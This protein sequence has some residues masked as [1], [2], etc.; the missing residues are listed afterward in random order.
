MRHL[1]DGILQA[2]LDRE[3]S[4]QEEAEAR[5]VADHL[6][7]CAE[8][9]ARA[10]ELDA[11]TRRSVALLAGDVGDEAVPAYREVLG[12]A[13]A[14]GR[15]RRRR[16]WTA[17]T[18]A[19][20]IAVALGAGWM[21][22]ELYRG[23]AA[24]ALAP[25][26][27]TVAS[28][29][30]SPLVGA[31]AREERGSRPDGELEA[32]ADAREAVV[33][34]EAAAASAAPTTTP[35]EPALTPTAQA[36][37]APATARRRVEVEPATG[38]VAANAAAASPRAAGDGPLADLAGD[39]VVRGRVVDA[40]TGRP[41]PAAQ[42]Y[43]ADLDVGVLT[44]QDGSFRLPL[45]EDDLAGGP[46]TL[47]VQRIGYRTENRDF[48][49]D[50]GDSLFMDFRIHEEALQLDEIIVTGTASGTERRALG[51][52]VARLTVA[53]V[54]AS[55]PALFSAEGWTAATAERAESI[56]GSR[57]RSVGALDVIGYEVGTVAGA[58]A[59]RVRQALGPNA[60]LSMIQAKESWALNGE[61][62]PD[63]RSVAL[64]RHGDVTLIAAAPLTLD[65]L[66][67]L[68]ARVR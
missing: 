61:A 4:G 52:A 26:P 19:A 25:T 58:D 43:I 44:L 9:A 54:S 45:L 68:L 23:A 63:G 15:P 29:V 39:P 33:A 53:S 5:S 66:N 7:A 64:R 34:N 42:V 31:G 20:S 47:T 12:R 24:P 2:W 46:V 30:R 11:L 36:P 51:S 40:Q 22:N 14:L 56:L 8:C 13:R 67:A 32:G 27:E 28:D 60:V 21:G 3:R 50:A 17:G 10:E 16:A 55:D 62:T 41:I 57:A 35:P 18:W 38:V 6:E 49:A 59:V 48:S 37:P 1:D 65:S